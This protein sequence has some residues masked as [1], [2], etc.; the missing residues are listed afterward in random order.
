MTH[1]AAFAL[2]FGG[3]L[4]LGA[5]IAAWLFRTT[6]APL[7]LKIATPTTMMALACCAP[8]SVASMM[9]FPVSASLESLPDQAELIA[10]VPH[11]DDGRV[12]LWLRVSDVPRAYDAALTAQMKQTLRDAARELELGRRP[13]LAKRAEGRSGGEMGAA[14]GRTGG[15]DRLGIGRDDASYVLEQSALFQ[16]PKK[17]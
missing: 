1:F 5:L 16:L 14:D 10:F 8:Y 13:F 2:S 9:G 15:G 7:W 17:D 4:A 3:F 12:D 11:D 6:A